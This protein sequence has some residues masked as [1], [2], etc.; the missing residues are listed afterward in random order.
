MN[1]APSIT[2]PDNA[3]SS[4]PLYLRNI[5]KHESCD[6][7]ADD[8]LETSQPS[9]PKCLRRLT[10][11]RLCS[12]LCNSPTTGLACRRQDVARPHV[13][14]SV[15]HQR[16]ANRTGQA[17]G[18]W[19]QLRWLVISDRDM[20]AWTGKGR[21]FFQNAKT[22]KHWCCRPSSTAC[23]APRTSGISQCAA[24]HTHLYPGRKK[25]ETRVHCGTAGWQ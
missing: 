21:E 6:E 19:R 14:S 5:C 12:R 16:R 23:P 25:G 22:S 8:G 7:D 24:Q 15:L 4:L 18:V 13:A 3:G 1:L 10:P 2:L 11:S 17:L 20:P 9:P